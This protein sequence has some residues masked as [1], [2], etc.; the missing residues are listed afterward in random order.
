MAFLYD[1]ESRKWNNNNDAAC[2]PLKLMSENIDGA[3]FQYGRFFVVQ[4]PHDQLVVYTKDQLGEFVCA[5][6]KVY[7]KMEESLG[8][9]LDDEGFCEDWGFTNSAHEK[10]DL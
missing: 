3:F 5:L 7:D 6:R 9:P 1:M 4:N 10:E 2:D 8:H